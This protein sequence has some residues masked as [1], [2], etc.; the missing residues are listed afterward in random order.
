MPGLPSGRGWRQGLGDPRQLEG[1]KPRRETYTLEG[2]ESKVQGR[3]PPPLTLGTQG[4]TSRV[5]P[6]FPTTAPLARFSRLHRHLRPLGGGRGSRAR[7]VAVLM[8][9]EQSVP[10]RLPAR[11]RSYRMDG[12]KPANFP[13]PGSGG[14]GPRGP[15]PVRVDTQIWLRAQEAPGR[16]MVLPR[17][18]P[19]IYPGPEVWGLPPV[20]PAYEFQGGMVR[21]H[22]VPCGPRV[23]A[24]EAG[25]W[26]PDP[27]EGTFPRPC[28]VMRC[29]PRL[30]L[31]E[32][33]SAVKKEV[34]QLAKDLRQKR[35]TLGYSQADVGFA[36]GALFGKV[37]SQTTI[38]RFEAQQLSL[39]NMW[40]LRPLLKMWLE[41]VDA[42]NLLGL[43]KMK[44]ILQQARKQRQASRERRIGNNL[45][46]LFLQCP[47][48][49]PQQ[50][51]HIAEQLRL[52]K[53][54]VRVWFYNRSKM[55]GWPSNDFSPL[56]EVEAAGPPF[57]GGPVCFP[58]TSGLH[59]G[60]PH[61]ARPYFTPL[62]S[63]AP[64]T[65]GGALLSERPRPPP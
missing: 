47:K 50:I 8:P 12:H 2:V 22:P 23:G 15:V 64:F 11:E 39:A 48:P 36:L 34:E 31:P 21:A 9:R 44:M 5:L 40:K 26:F 28:I 57:P 35:M 42:E 13:L 60:S 62:Y 27:S 46:K 20:P 19:R 1:T 18:G 37:L 16:L 45:E 61:Y 17:V 55:G 54:L 41:Q 7:L 51:C 10:T 43:C 33:V 30:A 29:I 52:Q 63:P 65:A 53:D 59:F 4:V 38:C 14:G 6:D 24:G 49:T 25:T 32:D 3:R 58:L 56:E